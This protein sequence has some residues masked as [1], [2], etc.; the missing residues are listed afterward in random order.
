VRQA[1]DES[2]AEPIRERYFAQLADR[3]GR[4][5]AIGREQASMRA[6]WQM[7]A[8]RH[9]ELRAEAN[10]LRPNVEHWAARAADVETEGS[11]RTEYQGRLHDLERRLEYLHAELRT[12]EHEGLRARDQLTRHTAALDDAQRRLDET[13]Q[14]IAAELFV[15]IVAPTPPELEAR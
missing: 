10:E 7:L 13:L 14:T 12:L 5:E 15:K 4:M 3:Q 11:A 8:R 1:L 9:D 2:G 6:E